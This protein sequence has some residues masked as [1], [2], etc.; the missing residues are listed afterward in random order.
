MGRE[1][2]H[3]MTA[4]SHLHIHDSSACLVSSPIAIII[5]NNIILVV[6]Y[7][8]VMMKIKYIWPCLGLLGPV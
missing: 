4:I 1:A 5:I 8:M 2:C 7:M 6:I 3:E